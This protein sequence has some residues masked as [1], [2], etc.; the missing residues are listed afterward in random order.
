MRRPVIAFVLGVALGYPVISHSKGQWCN[1]TTE[2]TR[3]TLTL[4]RSTVGGKDAPAPPSGAVFTLAG[5]PEDE[6]AGR[7]RDPDCVGSNAN[8][9]D[10]VRERRLSK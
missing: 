1:D 2:S 7:L 4:K 5:Q 10:G 9:L 8:C 6:V 3:V